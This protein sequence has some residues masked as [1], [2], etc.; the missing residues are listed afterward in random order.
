MSPY[1]PPEWL[2]RFVRVE[3]RPLLQKNAQA[4]LQA[5]KR[6]SAQLTEQQQRRQ[7][8]ENR[9]N[10]HLRQLVA[11]SPQR[12]DAP[13]ESPGEGWTWCESWRDPSTG[14]QYH[15]G[16][17]LPPELSGD[18]APPVYDNPLRHLIVRHHPVMPNLDRDN[19]PEE[20]WVAA[21]AIHDD[22]R[23]PP[24]RIVQ[25]DSLDSRAA[26]RFA[27]VSGS[28]RE[29]T[30]EHLPEL[31]HLLRIAGESLNKGETRPEGHGRRPKRK[32]SR[33]SRPRGEQV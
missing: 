12:S 1:D 16:A 28:V 6:W 30:E 26:I 15:L 29:L 23:V 9:R 4:A 31:L 10:E 5:L 18:N 2:R 21:L 11:N 25:D 27:V 22:V 14:E 17:W 24:E 3:V 32:R 8:W 13:P 33:H 7:E 20:C 19:A